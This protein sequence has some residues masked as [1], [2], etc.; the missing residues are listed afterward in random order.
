MS[1]QENNDV[2]ESGIETKQAR[3]E[4]GD[5]VNVLEEETPKIALKQLRNTIKDYEDYITVPN[6]RKSDFAFREYVKN[7]LNQTN[8]LIKEIH[9]MLIEKQQM[10]VWAVADNLI[11]ETASFSRDVDKCDYGFTTFFENPKL[12]AIDIS[13]LYLIENDI[14][15]TL[16][17]MNERTLAFM[18]MVGRN[19]LEDVDLWF[20]TLDRFVGRLIKLHDDRVKLIG[21]YERISY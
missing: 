1:E 9:A 3:I 2:E 4:I 15:K 6:R 21:S 8:D 17:V 10:S 13:Q 7:Y 20:E 5:Q 18:D 11:N 16:R 14:L 19:Y 12:L